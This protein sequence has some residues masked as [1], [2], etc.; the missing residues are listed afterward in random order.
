VLDDRRIQLLAATSA[1]AAAATIAARALP[2]V[3]TQWSSPID[4]LAVSLIAEPEVL[5]LLAFSA[6]AVSLSREPR[7][8][9][10]RWTRVAVVGAAAVQVPSVLWTAW[11]TVVTRG[12]DDATFLVAS[13]AAQ[14]SIYLLLG[15]VLFVAIS[16]GVLSARW[17]RST[18]EGSPR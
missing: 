6:A 14:A 10:L 8:P 9:L 13:P 18:A 17:S 1:G 16:V 3:G 15:S 5:V 4:L 7:S 12:S 2:F 11:R